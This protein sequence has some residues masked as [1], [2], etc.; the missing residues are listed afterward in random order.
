MTAEALRD[1][2]GAVTKHNSWS[3]ARMGEMFGYSLSTTPG[4]EFKDGLMR[5]RFD[6]VVEAARAARVKPTAQPE[7]K[8]AAAATVAAAPSK[9]AARKADGKKAAAK[10]RGSR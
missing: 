1:A 10:N 4:S 8:R 7:E 2:V 3:L 6:K 5:Y 9:R